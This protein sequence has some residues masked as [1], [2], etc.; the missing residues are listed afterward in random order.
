MENKKCDEC[1][2]KQA[3]IHLTQIVQNE[4]TVIHLCEECAKKKGI[5]VV[6]EGEQSSSL[7]GL[8]DDNQ[9]NN[10]TPEPEKKITC[11]VCYT[12]FAEFKKNG[13]LGCSSCYRAFEKEIEELLIQVHG[14]SQHKGK[15]YSESLLKTNLADDMKIL[16]A[17]LENAVRSE[18]FELAALIRDK[19]K[20]SSMDKS[21]TDI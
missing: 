19:I 15:E 18:K 14:S 21:T 7:K 11:P 17:E 2:V 12:T 20:S 3:N 16:R 8:F 1:K 10:S 4:V 13:W 5:S 9:E 6:I